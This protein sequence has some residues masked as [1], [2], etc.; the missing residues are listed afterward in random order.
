LI[1]NVNIQSIERCS[2]HGGTFG[3]MEEGH[4]IAMKVGKPVFSQTIKL[5]NKTTKENGGMKKNKTKKKEK[6]KTKQNKTNKAKQTH[7]LETIISSEC[8]LAMDHIKQGV[9]ETLNSSSITKEIEIKNLST[10]SPI[11]LIAKSY[12]LI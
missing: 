5:F 4:E 9:S 10:M 6:N 2:G 11:E 7:I 8:P 3:V 1:P 12:G